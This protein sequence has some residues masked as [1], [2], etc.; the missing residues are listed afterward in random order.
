MSLAKFM[1]YRDSIRYVYIPP[2][3]IKYIYRQNIYSFN[4]TVFSGCAP[5]APF[6]NSQYD[7]S[8]VAGLC[9]LR[10]IYSMS[11][12]RIVSFFRENGFELEKPTA[13]HLLSKTAVLFETSMKHSEK[14][15]L[16]IPTS[17]VTKHITKY[18]FRE[19]Q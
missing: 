11:V 10:Y 15:C 7:G 1:G 13:H 16:K 19:E 14:W 17:V 6:L 18:W 9:Q 3:F 5:A 12:E 8:F 2:K 4:E